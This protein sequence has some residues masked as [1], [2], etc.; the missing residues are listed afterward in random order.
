LWW[1]LWWRFLP[2]VNSVGRFLGEW[3]CVARRAVGVC[4]V[5]CERLTMDE[6]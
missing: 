4:V 6:T 5:K 2:D 1:C 3:V